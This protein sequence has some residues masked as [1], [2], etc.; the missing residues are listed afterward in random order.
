M[1]ENTCEV[2]GNHLVAAGDLSRDTGTDFD[3]AC[4]RVLASSDGE[5]VADLAGVDHFCST[6][7]G[8]LAELCLSA[9]KRGKKVVIRGTGATLPVLKEAGLAS[10]ARI[11]EVG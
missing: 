3:D 7:V 2:H 4:Q 10:V 8:L 6:Y 5:I 11:E 9:R 1:G